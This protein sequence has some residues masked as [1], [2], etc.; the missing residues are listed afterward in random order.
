MASASLFDQ[1]KYGAQQKPRR[2]TSILV[3]EEEEIEFTQLESETIPL[4][5]NSNNP[6]AI[7]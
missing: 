7:I 2:K 4:V 3:Q 5:E 1:R 6:L